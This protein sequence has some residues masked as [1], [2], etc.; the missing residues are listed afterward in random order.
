MTSS[1]CAQSSSRSCPFPISESPWLLNQFGQESSSPTTHA[2][3]Q[4]WRAVSRCV[5]FFDAENHNSCPCQ[6]DWQEEWKQRQMIMMK[7]PSVGRQRDMRHLAELKD[8]L[9]LRYF[10]EICMGTQGLFKMLNIIDEVTVFISIATNFIQKWI[11]FVLWHFIMFILLCFILLRLS[12]QVLFKVVTLYF[13]GYKMKYLGPNEELQYTYQSVG[14]YKYYLTVN[15][16]WRGFESQF[17][18]QMDIVVLLSFIGK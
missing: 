18:S 6:H 16:E 11:L 3:K 4:P 9:S 12:D 14:S 2:V 1:F 7:P 5:Q 15:L 10:A 8:I 17:E 13:R